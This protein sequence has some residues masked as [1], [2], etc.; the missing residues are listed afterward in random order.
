MVG[1][2]WRTCELL[3]SIGFLLVGV[4]TGLLAV[5]PTQRQL[6]TMTNRSWSLG[7][8]ISHS[9]SL[10]WCLCTGCTH[11]SL[12]GGPSRGTC[13]HCIL[14]CHR[15]CIAL[16]TGMETH[17]QQHCL[18]TWHKLRC[19]SSV[20]RGVKGAEC[21]VCGRAGSCARTLYVGLQHIAPM[22]FLFQAHIN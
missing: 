22:C 7:V 17:V 13:I 11:Q 10:P 16:H 5:Q 8:H 15:T 1:L 20:C 21:V 6:L 14:C 18:G 4:L 19:R 2:A 9:S 12:S 3:A